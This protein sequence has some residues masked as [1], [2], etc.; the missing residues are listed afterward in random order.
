MGQSWCPEQTPYW[1]FDMSPKMPNSL[2]ETKYSATGVSQRG[3]NGF[4]RREIHV[5]L[6]QKCYPPAP[7][8]GCQKNTASRDA[9]FAAMSKDVQHKANQRG[10]VRKQEK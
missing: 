3:S 8:L 2:V 7:L 9:F 1:P 10:D 5:P 6:P 4:S